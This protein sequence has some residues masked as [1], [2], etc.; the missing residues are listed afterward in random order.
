MRNLK[1]YFILLF[2]LLVVFTYFFSSPIEGFLRK[3]IPEKIYLRMSWAKSIF[4][5]Q[6]FGFYKYELRL[7]DQFSEIYDYINNEDFQFTLKE[8]K[9]NDE[10]NFFKIP[11]LFPAQDIDRTNLAYIDFFKNDLI[12]ATKNGVFFKVAIDDNEANFNP[13]K[14]N[15]YQFFEKKI[16]E[17]RAS[18]NYFNPLT[19]SKFG[20]KDILVDND[21]LYIS[22]IENI[23][24]NNYN[25]SILRSQISDSLVFEKFY[26]GLV[27][28]SSDY[29]EFYPIQSGGRIVKFKQDSLL[30]S[31]GDFRKRTEAQNIESN[32]GKIIA[33][34][35][36]DG[37]SRIVSIGHRNPQGLDYSQVGDYVISTEHGPAGGDEINLNLFPNDQTNFGWP[38]AS[39]GIHYFVNAAN[40]DG[41]GGDVDRVIDNAPI[42]KS[43]S[44]YGFEEPIKYY[45]ISPGISE[46]KFIKSNKNKLEFIVSTLGTHDTIKKPFMNHLIHYKYDLIDRNLTTVKKHFVGE[47]VRDLIFSKSLKKIF[48]TGET[49]GIIGY[50]DLK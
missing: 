50:M 37:G 4:T 49:T 8:K 24:E 29:E 2:I 46:V 5:S 34:S 17:K 36:S 43:H 33:I 47:R 23:N 35:K 27:G 13:I 45:E 30:L 22:Y 28:V 25:T 31:V 16:I 40:D 32:I 19:I 26:S 38:I 1:K 21:F 15:L 6:D 9:L 41:H 48:F 20:I 7:G 14:S 42:Y 3:N 11:P 12:Y 44:E 10:I 39:Y 18:I